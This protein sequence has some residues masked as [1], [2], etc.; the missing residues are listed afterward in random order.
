ML[1]RLLI[2]AALAALVAAGRGLLRLR[3]ARLLRA[4]GAE[5]PFAGVI[6]GG[7]PAVVA[8]TLPT[9]AECRARQQP[10]LLRLR[11]RLG[12]AVHIETVA[13]DAYGALTERLGILTVPATAVLDGAGA[14]RFLNQGF[15]D[16]TRLA[17][18]LAAVGLSVA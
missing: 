12:D 1:E 4:L 18:Q 7:R 11:S 14:L 10:A 3:Q 15:A 8:F 5:R 16:E 17:E 9:C 6:P 2:L 13:A